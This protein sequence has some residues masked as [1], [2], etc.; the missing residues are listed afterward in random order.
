[1]KHTLVV[2]VLDYVFHHRDLFDTSVDRNIELLELQKVSEARPPLQ[3]QFDNPHA[4][5]AT[6]PGVDYTSSLQPVHMTE[7]ATPPECSSSVCVCAAW[8]A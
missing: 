2:L 7:K 3:C 4:F 1:M 6:T 8:S 5:A